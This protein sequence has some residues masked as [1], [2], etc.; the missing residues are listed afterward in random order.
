MERELNINLEM[1][2]MHKILKIVE[3][4]ESDLNIVI[5][6][7]GNNLIELKAHTQ[8]YYDKIQFTD[9]LDSF[10]S[11]GQKWNQLINENKD[12]CFKFSI[13]YTQLSEL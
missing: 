6:D 1:K 7:A 3:I 5:R 12:G 10:N 11:K 8:Q 2:Q 9:L 4:M 13:E